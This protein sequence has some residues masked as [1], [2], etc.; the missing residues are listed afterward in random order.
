MEVRKNILKDLELEKEF[1]VIIPQEIITTEIEK[2][3][4]DRQKTYRLDGFRK[5]K[6][7][8]ETIRKKE[9]NSYFY[10]ISEDYINKFVFS[11]GRDNGYNLAL[12]PK[13]TLKTLNIGDN[14]EFTVIYELMPEIG[15]IDFAGM[16]FEKF[17]ISVAEED[18]ENSL[19]K[20]LENHKKFTKKES[21][22]QMGDSVVIDFSGTID[23]SVFAGSS[24]ENYHLE[25]GSGSFVG[26][27]EEQIV[28]K[29]SG[30]EFNVAVTFP[31]NYHKSSLA[32][33]LAIFRVKLID[34]LG[35]EKRTLDDEF[36]K[37]T[38]GVEDVHK[39]REL[40]RD[41]LARTYEKL[42]VDDLRE[43]IINYLCDHFTFSL[44][45]GLVEN[46]FNSLLRARKIKNLQNSD[47]ADIDN[48]SLRIEAEKIMKISLLLMKIGEDNGIEVN[49]SEL[50]QA[51]M[52]EAMNFPGKEK[53]VVD[54]YRNNS[55]AIRSMKNSVLENKIMDFMVNSV[56]KNEIDVSLV[57]FRDRIGE[58]N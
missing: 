40:I 10:K 47:T 12:E 57:Q 33:K 56:E 13:I 7:P 43:K 35:P 36:V 11:L 3:I 17:R 14:V 29:M 52:Q 16:S 50:S 46:Q 55:S 26:N 8:L 54:Y 25:L 39:F 20:I 42:S 4:V 18:I 27:F 19:E 2:A 5:G 49:E 32:R 48:E 44:P 28:G 37:G 53:I 21:A 9:S 6:V 41:E 58:K 15:K 34:V 30:E 51:V 24:A 31:E 45:R 22:A 38:F 1:E 23:G